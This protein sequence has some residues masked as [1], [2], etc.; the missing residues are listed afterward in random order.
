MTVDTNNHDPRIAL[1][2]R[3]YCEDF[4]AFVF[5]CD[6]PCYCEKAINAAIEQLENIYEV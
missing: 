3:S 2:A 4:C 1:F 6:E 5:E